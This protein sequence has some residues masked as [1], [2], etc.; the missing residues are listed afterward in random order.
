MKVMKEGHRMKEIQYRKEMF[1][2][3][4]DTCQLLRILN[5]MEGC[6]KGETA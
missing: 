3:E 5:E 2:E 1:A 6:F 4:R